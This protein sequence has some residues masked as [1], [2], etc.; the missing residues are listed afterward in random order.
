MTVPL[1]RV[2]TGVT[3]EDMRLS[4]GGRVQDESDPAGTHGSAPATLPT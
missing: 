3:T 4:V 2:V 1:Q